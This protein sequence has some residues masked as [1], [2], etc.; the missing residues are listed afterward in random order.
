[1]NRND[2][3]HPKIFVASVDDAG[4]ASIEKEMREFFAGHPR[5]HSIK[6]TQ[7]QG[8][9]GLVLALLYREPNV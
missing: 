6:M 5:A 1:M 8:D 7:S 2:P 4:I 3:L 9:D